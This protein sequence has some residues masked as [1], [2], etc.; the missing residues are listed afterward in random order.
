MI[1][2]MPTPARVL[3]IWVIDSSNTDALPIIAETSSDKPLLINL[4]DEEE[5]SLNSPLVTL[6]ARVKSPITKAIT[7][8]TI[9][10]PAKVRTKSLA[11]NAN[12]VPPK[13]FFILKR[14]RCN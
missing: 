12:I 14:N 3:V 4:A 8:S 11:V 10:A 5:I 7:P 9:T 1:R 13:I 2:N 6:N